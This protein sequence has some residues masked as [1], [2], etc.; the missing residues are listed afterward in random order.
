L[1]TWFERA[2]EAMT[3]QRLPRPLIGALA[4]MKAF[5]KLIGAALN[6]AFVLLVVGFCLTGVLG[7]YLTSRIEQTTLEHRLRV[8]RL[9][10]DRA[11]AIRTLHDKLVDVETNLLNLFYNYRPIGVS[12]AFVEPKDVVL[13]V[14]DLRTTFEKSR[15]YFSIDLSARLDRVCKGF[16]DALRDLENAYVRRPPRLPVGEAPDFDQT[17][18]MEHFG[19]S[20]T[21]RSELEEEFRKILGATTTP[22]TLRTVFGWL[23]FV[24]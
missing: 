8:S 15:I 4:H 16:E 17:K 14:R 11:L 10:E 2:A 23:P 18:F 7:A 6:S 1:S 5:M 24:G 22:T 12:P 13:S 3:H 21:A 20:K 9:H 19:R